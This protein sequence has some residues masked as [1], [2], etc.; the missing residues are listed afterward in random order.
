MTSAT[1]PNE[2]Q[3]HWPDLL[4]FSRSLTG[5]IDL[6]EDI[7]QESILRA[8]Q[9]G[10]ELAAVDNP[11]G[12]LFQIAVNVFRQ[13]W[14]NRARETE[15]WQQLAFHRPSEFRP[16]PDRLAEQREHLETIWRFI[17]SLPDA[18]R[19]VIVMHLVEGRSHDEIAA[20]MQ[21]SV[22]SVKASLSVARRKL[23]MRF[24]D[25]RKDD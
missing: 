3:E 17:E 16:L 21:T 5:N 18:Q 15:R 6:A 22:G 13:W 9:I 25:N 11:R 19:Q 1:V 4:R 10:P 14:R 20:T 7:A 23:R 2:L 8:L 24:L 12:Y